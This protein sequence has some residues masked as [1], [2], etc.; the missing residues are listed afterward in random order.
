MSTVLAKK[1]MT[2]EDIKLNY[3]TPAIMKGWKGHI[4]METKIT[5]GRIN[6]RGNIVA[7]SKPKF[8]DYMLY[9]NDGKPI[10]VVEAKDN[11]HSVSHGLQQAMTY[12][13]MMD[14][15]FA[16]SSNGDA[17]YEHNFL[18]GQEQQITLDK[19]PTQDELV[20]RYYAELNGGKGISDLEKKIVSQPYYSSQSTYPPRYYQR[21]AVNRTVEAIARG[22]QRLLLVMAT[23]TGKTYTAFQIVYRLLRSDLKKRILYLADRNILVDQS[24]AQDFAPLEKTIYKVDF[25][26]KE[27]L[28]EIASHEV[29]FALYHQMVGQNDEEHFRQIPPEYFDLIVVDECHRGSAKEDSNWRK[30]LEYFSSATQIGMTATPKESEKVSN[31]DYFGE[32]V[33]IYSLKQGIEDGF[34][35][36]FKVINITTNIGDGWRP[37]HGQTDIYGNVIEDRIYNNRDYD[38]NII[39]QDR[40]NEVAREITEYLK[41][42]NRMQKTI[43]FCAS[44][45]HAERMRIALINHNSDMVKES[46]DYC[47]RITG[48]DV[49]GKSKLDYFISVSEPYPVIATTSELLSTGADCKMTKLIVLDKTVESMTTFKQIIG[50]GTRIREKDGKTHFIVMDFR[51]VTR[52]FSDPDWDGPVEQ[53][54]GFQH[55]SSKPKGG[56]HGG[57]GGKEPPVDPVEPPIVDKDGCRV[58]I[59]NK[60]VSVY[61]ANGKLLRQEDIIDY[62]RTNIKGEYASLSDFIRKWKTS[63][64]KKTIEESFMAMGI[65]LKAL[66]ADQGMEDV[67]DFDFI[68]YVAYGKKPLTRKERANN[69]KKKDF[70]SKYSADA[71]AVLDILLDKYMNQGITE[72]EDIK[73][74]SLADFANYGK[75]AKIVKLFGGKEQYVAAVRELEAS[76]YEEVEVG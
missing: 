24:I 6:I 41:S 2:E 45:D 69:V 60:T 37:Y 8:V 56:G 43:V 67:D 75:P 29:N 31:I 30:V 58:K 22:Q 18:T 5:D 32:P 64:K 38:Y 17:F 63:D 61:D 53:D 33:Y 55:G 48:S 4:T 21:N 1:Q 19:F 46:P 51:N 35:A 49:Y 10:A 47:V 65:D 54:E 40:I 3:I 9:L 27:C 28:R 50:R 7:R 12:A 44:E 39:L 13:Q 74:L 76:I 52:L 26:D 59:I 25:S 16:Y 36:P 34:L 71:Q 72:V 11:N 23:G 62:T 70:F 15:P 20:A 57:G 73:V 68:C 66:K 42:T 14:L